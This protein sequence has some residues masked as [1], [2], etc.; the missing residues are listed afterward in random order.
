MRGVVVALLAATALPAYAADSCV[1]YADDD[2]IRQ[3]QTSSNQVT[4]VIPLRNPHR[5]VMNAEDCGVWTL[6]KHDRRILR[7]NADGD[8][9]RVIHVRTLHPRLDEVERLHLDPYDQ[10]LWVTD[11][12]RIFHISPMGELLGSLPTPGEI[13]RLRVALDQT[14]WVLGKRSLWRFD[15]SGTLLATYNLGRHLAGDARYFVV[16]GVGGLI[17][18]ADDNELAQVKVMDATAEPSLRVRMHHQIT[19]LALDPLSG[20]VWIARKDSLLAFSRSGTVSHRI[21]LDALGIRKPEKLAFDPV[22]R[23]LWAGAERSVSRFNEAGELIARFRARDGDEALGVPAFKLEPAL[24]LIRPP[25]DALTNNPQ[26]E[27]RL[28]YG[29]E[30]NGS[31]C[32]LLESYLSSHR[33]LATLNNQQIGDAFRFDAATGEAYHVPAARLPEGSNIFTAQVKDVFGH[34]SNSISNTFTVDTV[35][36]QF[37][38][39]SPADG[40]IFQTAQAIVQG[41]VDDPLATVTLETLGLTQ[42]G[43]SFSFPIVLQPGANIFKISAIDRAGNVVTTQRTLNFIPL[44]LSITSPSAGAT[45]TGSAVQVTGTVQ[46]PPNTGVTV[47]GVVAALAGDRFYASVPL[48][49]GSN[50]LTVVAKTQDGFAAQQTVSVT[51][52]GRALIEVGA[53]LPSGIAPLKVSFEVKASLGISISRIDADFDGNGSIDFTTTNLNAP[54]EFVYTQ[55]GVYPA[56][57]IITD[58]QGNASTHIVHIVVQNANAIDQQLRTLWSGLTEALAAG[59]RSAAMQYFNVRGQEKFGPVLE[60]L[61]PH[62]LQI[63]ASYSAPV[64]MS[65]AD[66]IGEYAIIR[67]NGTRHNVYLIYFLK[68]TDGVWRIDEM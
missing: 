16:D 46:G 35:A 2:S 7:F 48:Q 54:V 32:T 34:N 33:L 38:T 65:I 67:Q 25:Q 43:P 29:T 23:S 60:Q 45:I 6:D 4:R 49:T 51:S 26:P 8:L 27:F 31:A 44:N 37:L 52:T 1:W 56:R 28:G 53:P 17:W 19:G 47:N 21:D 36:P 59:N 41:T 3:V 64:T 58:N 24:T 62:M 68:D 14:L 63:V 30:C 12:R 13:R 18:L 9:E 20:T 50:A 10:S 61:L 39:L 5:L 40:A 57:L 42:T 11:E 66:R 22:S 15:S 55:P